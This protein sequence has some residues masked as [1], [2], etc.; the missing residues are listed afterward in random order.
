MSPQNPFD[1]IEQFFK[2]M[3]REFEESGLGSLRDISV[4][5]SETDDEFTVVAD[6]PGYE[7]DDIEISA[8]GRELT[9]RAEQT[10]E[11]EESGDRYVRRERRQSNV[12]RSL[13][14]PQEV[15]EEEAS[16]TYKNGVL[17]VTL[18]KET[19]EEDDESTSIDVV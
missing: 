9:I 1:E 19:S 14:L 18:P 3:G 17:T 12:R 15:V 2:R 8:S 13:T 16:A 11:T 10:A 4:D 6:L 5:V 7:K